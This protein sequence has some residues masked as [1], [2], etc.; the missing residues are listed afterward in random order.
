MIS[1]VLSRA[2]DNLDNCLVAPEREVLLL[3]FRGILP[4]R[5]LLWFVG[6]KAGWIC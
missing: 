5:S 4:S 3:H 6:V 1:L 2:Y